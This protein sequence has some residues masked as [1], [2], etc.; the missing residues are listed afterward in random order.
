MADEATARGLA[1]PNPLIGSIVVPPSLAFLQDGDLFVAPHIVL[2]PV[3]ESHAQGTLT[4]RHGRGRAQASTAPALST[5]DAL[6]QLGIRTVVRARNP[7]RIRHVSRRALA[8]QVL[9]DIEKIVPVYRLHLT[10]IHKC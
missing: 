1:D 9:G 7:R 2:A 4:D 10:N 6:Q 3:E 8:E 5:I